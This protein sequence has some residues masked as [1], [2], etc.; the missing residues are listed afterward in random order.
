M[1]HELS[2][3]YNNAHNFFHITCP[4][5][6][7]IT[8]FNTENGDIRSY[9]GCRDI[10]APGVL[11][12]EHLRAKYHCITESEHRRLEALKEEAYNQE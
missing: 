5:G 7:Y 1:A 9:Y 6:D 2:I 4:E 10:Y 3:E 8:D 11:T 12:E